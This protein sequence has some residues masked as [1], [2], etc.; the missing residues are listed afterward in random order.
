MFLN[1]SSKLKSSDSIRKHLE[2]VLLHFYSFTTILLNI[3]LHNNNSLCNS[4]LAS[5]FL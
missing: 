2:Q 3:Y 5:K 4:M 1:K